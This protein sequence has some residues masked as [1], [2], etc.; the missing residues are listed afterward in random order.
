MAIL[1]PRRAPV[2]VALALCGALLAAPAAAGGPRIHEVAVGSNFYDPPKLT[3]NRGERV[4]WEWEPGFKRHDV[5]VRRGPERF[6]SPIQSSG[7]Y[8]R[9]FRKPGTFK[10]YCSQHTMRM[11]LVVRR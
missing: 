11:T 7:T 4:R 10:L 6:R 5:A 1:D 3:I 2:A 8:A 9:T